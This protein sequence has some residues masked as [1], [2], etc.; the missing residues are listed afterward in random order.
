MITKSINPE[1]TTHSVRL[2]GSQESRI[3]IALKFK[4]VVFDVSL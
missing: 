2:N 4:K 3:Q 1:R